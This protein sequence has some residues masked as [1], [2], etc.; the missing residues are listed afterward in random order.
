MVSALGR[1]GR[2]G[3]KATRV[4][5]ASQRI[6]TSGPRDETVRIYHRAQ[7]PNLTARPTQWPPQPMFA[8]PISRFW[9]SVRA[10][11]AE[12]NKRRRIP[13]PR[14]TRRSEAEHAANHA[15]IWERLSTTIDIRGTA[16]F[17]PVR[18]EAKAMSRWG[19]IS[20]DRN[21]RHTLGRRTVQLN[22]RVRLNATRPAMTQARARSL[23]DTYT[24][25]D[26]RHCRLPVYTSHSKS[27]V[28]KYSHL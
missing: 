27:R 23:A 15:V 18:S 22:S 9:S 21:L 8:G 10:R 16:E 2:N 12:I 1:Y 25:N 24:R 11:R 5:A 17:V 14:R 7:R 3:R 13:H 28:V 6:R 20:T 4:M 19:G 26:H